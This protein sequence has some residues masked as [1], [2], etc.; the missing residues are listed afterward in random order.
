MFNNVIE[1]YHKTYQMFCFDTSMKNSFVDSPGG[2]SACRIIERRLV[3]R[4]E[5]SVR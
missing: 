1:L 3:G 4:E 5:K 2:Q